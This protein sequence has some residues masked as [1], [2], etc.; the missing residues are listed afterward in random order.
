MDAAKLQL[1]HILRPLKQLRGFIMIIFITTNI[2]WIYASASLGGA[3]GWS[4]LC[5]CPRVLYDPDVNTF[6][7]E[8]VCSYNCHSLKH[9]RD[10]VQWHSN[11]ICHYTPLSAILWWGSSS[12]F[13][14]PLINRISKNAP[15]D[16]LVLRLSGF[17]T[18]GAVLRC[19]L[20]LMKQ[21]F[22]ITGNGIR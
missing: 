13:N 8:L 12:L 16:S 22:N 4:K 17:F 9:I 1:R 21:R 7:F 10:S 14:K 6:F 18:F 19:H 20:I 3:L 2:K 15:F 5:F 11:V